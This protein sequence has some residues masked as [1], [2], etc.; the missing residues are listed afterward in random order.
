MCVWKKLA[1]KGAFGNTGRLKSKYT[2]YI[3]K[4]TLPT[5]FLLTHINIQTYFL[6]AWFQLILT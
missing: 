2:L 4:C 5:D 1:G 3:V 6:Y